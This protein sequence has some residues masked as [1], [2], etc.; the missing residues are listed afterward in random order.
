M[1]DEILVAEPLGD[2]L[3]VEGF[4]LSSGY[5]AISENSSFAAKLLNGSELSL[6]TYGDENF[7]EFEWS[8]IKDGI[9]QHTSS[10]S[11]WNIYFFIYRLMNLNRNILK[12]VRSD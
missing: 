5:S 8:F 11:I 6:T 9:V 2:A 12:A 3:L 10:K 4:N 7:F 1:S